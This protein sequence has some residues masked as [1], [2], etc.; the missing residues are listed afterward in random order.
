MRNAVRFVTPTH[1]YEQRGRE[2]EGKGRG[3]EGRERGG[4]GEKWGQ[5]KEREGIEGRLIYYSAKSCNET[6]R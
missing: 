3:K 2:G 5:K 6:I 1:W 4:R